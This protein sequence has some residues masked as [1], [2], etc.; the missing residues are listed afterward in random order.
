[1]LKVVLLGGE[2][3]DSRAMHVLA[4]TAVVGAL[5][6]V[7]APLLIHRDWHG[8]QPVFTLAEALL[9]VLAAGLQHGPVTTLKPHR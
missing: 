8:L 1:M 6:S 5:A 4:A 9:V 3:I 2:P 7:S